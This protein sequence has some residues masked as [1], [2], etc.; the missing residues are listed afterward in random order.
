[1]KHQYWADYSLDHSS[2]RTCCLLWGQTSCNTGGAGQKASLCRQLAPKREREEG[3]VHS[4]LPNLPIKYTAPPP[5][6]ESAWGDMERPGLGDVLWQ[7]R[8][9]VLSHGW[10][11]R[12]GGSALCYQP[13]L[14][15]EAG[16]GRPGKWA[17]AG[18]KNNGGRWLPDCTWHWLLLYLTSVLSLTLYLLFVICSTDMVEIIQGQKWTGP[19]APFGVPSLGGD[20]PGLAPPTSLSPLP[21]SFLYPRASVLSKTAL[22]KFIYCRTHHHDHTTINSMENQCI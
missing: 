2:T 20:R 18:Q 14:V 1:M 5:L 10:N 15:A 21:V 12:G 13:L 3:A 9:Q 4:F 19:T 16:M 6:W 17:T 8:I 11:I 7:L 22:P